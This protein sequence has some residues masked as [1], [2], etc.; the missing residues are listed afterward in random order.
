MTAE[1]GFLQPEAA[2]HYSSGYEATRLFGSPQG[3][4]ERIR[5]Q[6][7]IGRYLPRAPA[8]VIARTVANG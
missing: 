4:L 7:I 6:E 5:S 1:S 8:R 2:Q 3:E